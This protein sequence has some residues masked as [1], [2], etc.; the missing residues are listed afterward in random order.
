MCVLSLSAFRK[1]RW[2]G[3]E[4]DELRKK[5][6]LLARLTYPAWL[7]VLFDDEYLVWKSRH[8][9]MDPISAKEKRARRRTL[10]FMLN[11]MLLCPNQL[12]AF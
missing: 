7:F 5:Y 6:A 8:V 11:R 4:N 12:A 10:A 1:H 2:K 9:M 3:H